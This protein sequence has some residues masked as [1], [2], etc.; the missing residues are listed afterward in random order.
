MKAKKPYI[1]YKGKQYTL[2]PK[3]IAKEQEAHK[4]GL[5]QAVSTKETEILQALLSIGEFYFIHLLS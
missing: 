4:C 3:L 5:R 2:I 1:E